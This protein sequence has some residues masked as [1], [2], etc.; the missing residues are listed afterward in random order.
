MISIHPDQLEAMLA[1]AAHRGAKQTIEDMDCC[2]YKAKP[3]Y[4]LQHAAEADSR[5]QNQACGWTNY[6]RETASIPGLKSNMKRMEPGPHPCLKTTI[7]PCFNVKLVS[8][9]SH[10]GIDARWL[11]KFNFKQNQLVTLYR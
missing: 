7:S 10:Q 5:R 8:L 11:H 2:H 9:C 4:Q 6:K 1:G 3:G